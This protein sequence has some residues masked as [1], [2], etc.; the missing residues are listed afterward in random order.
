MAIDPVTLEILKN[1]CRAAAESMAFTLYRTAHSTF[2]KETEDFTTGLTTVEGLTFATPVELGATWFVGLNYANVIKAIEHYDEGDIAMT[3]DPYSGSVCTHSPDM[4]IWKPVFHDG[5]IVCYVVG[6]IHNTDVGGAVPA[7]ISRTLSEVHQE[8][9]RIP[10]AKIVRRGEINHDVLDVL[11]ANVRMPEQN[12]GDLKAQI[13]AMNTGERRVHE[14]IEKFGIETFRT[15]IDALLDYAEAQARE[16]MRELP[17]GR[18]DFADYLDE[19]VVDGYPCRIALSLEIKGDGCT[20]DFT[21][22]DPQI[23]GSVNMPTG[24]E[25]RHALLMVGLVYVLYSLNP[26][27]FLNAGVCRICRSIL[28]EGTI[29]NPQFPA[30]VGLRTLSVQR[31][32]G[33]IFGA[34]A[35]AAPDRLPS[36]PASGGP[37]MNVNTID[38]RTGR[39]VVASIGPITGGAGGNPREDGT[40]GSGAN[41]S[42]LKNTPVEINEVEVPIKIL[43][44]G[45]TPDS[46]GPGKYRGGMATELRF[47]AQAPNTRITARNRDRSRFTSWGVLGGKA[48][49]RSYFTLNPGS[50]HEVDL[51]NTDILRVG[52]GDV[53]HIGSGGAGGWG[54][55]LERDTDAVR[56][57]VLRHLVSPE[58]AEHD[59]GVVLANGGIDVGATAQLRKRLGAERR[60][61]GGFFDY[62]EQRTAFERLW[63]KDNYGALTE[64]LA[65]LPV[66]WRFFV[67]HRVFEAIDA[68]AEDERAGDGT[69]V[70]TCFTRVVDRYPQLKALL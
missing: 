44:Y 43:R 35:Q 58:A 45:L 41:A 1:H 22:S 70:R 63:T 64:L 15:G 4:H 69:E 28:P 12:W 54:D 62:G 16:I 13:A 55:P 14:M 42:F 10:P 66:H 2:V 50:N 27:L 34:F 57:D 37:I 38:N 51:G 32:Q 48:G 26:R 23:E 46:G 3:N 8:G 21:G 67:K 40:E 33:V 18:Y 52:P 5:E 7:S 39:R 30:A 59:Y 65:G 25:E 49:S 53:V 9:I 17:D 19:D 24:G 61:G 20:F 68:L 31:L 36:S 56:V 29:V 6:H 60:N 11:L 47:E